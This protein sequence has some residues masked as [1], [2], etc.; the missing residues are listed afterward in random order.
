ML[1]AVVSLGLAATCR[2]SWYQPSSI[3][4][5]MLHEDKRVL[6]RLIDEIGGALNSQEQTH[7]RLSAAQ[8]NRWI[9][10]RAEMWPD[11]ALDDLG[12]LELPF[13]ALSDAGVRVAATAQHDGWQGVVALTC[14]IEVAGEWVYLHC[15][16]ARLG[17][18]PVPR[19]L[20]SELVARIPSAS[21]TVTGSKGGQTVRI[22]NEWIWPNG[23]R[24]CRLREVAVSDGVVD[25]VLE[26]VHEP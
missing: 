25:V 26:P 14:R 9:V 15:G 8:I 23:K 12:P 5:S 10:A 20:V 16:S 19:D 4:H 18:V 7:F 22:R 24:R 11:I 17:A 13:V 3:D 1:A 21:A 2:P 6:V